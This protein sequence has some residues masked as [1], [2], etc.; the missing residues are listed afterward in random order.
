MVRITR[1]V[2]LSFI[3]VLMISHK[4]FHFISFQ[5]DY[6]YHAYIALFFTWFYFGLCTLILSKQLIP[7]VGILYVCVDCFAWIACGKTWNRIMIVQIFPQTILSS[8]KI[9]LC[10]FI[11]TFDSFA[12]FIYNY[13]EL[14]LRVPNI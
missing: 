12:F 11:C 2:S 9:F 4:K 7:M 6:F 1:L 3:G 14:I 13:R 8:M 5:F 10:F